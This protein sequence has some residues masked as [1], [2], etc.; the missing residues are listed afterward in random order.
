MEKQKT[1]K[2]LICPLRKENPLSFTAFPPPDKWNDRGPDKC[3]S[4]CGSMHPEYFLKL[5]P[6]IKE[7]SGDIY[8]DLADRRHK[9]Y[10]NRKGI[11]NAGD[12]AIKVYL[13]HVKQWCDDQGMSQEEIHELDKQINAALLKSD[14]IFHNIIFPR[15]KNE[16]L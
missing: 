10:I 8:I 14:K 7:D 6:L 13:A 3:C 9:I 2:P 4:Y 12:G 16:S 11:A 5:L 15:I 1:E